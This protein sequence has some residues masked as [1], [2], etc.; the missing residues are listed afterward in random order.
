VSYLKPTPLAELIHLRARIIKIEGRKAWVDCAL[1]AA[2]ELRA[3]G[4]V[5]GVRVNWD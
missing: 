3:T 4:E 1:T 5:L 2:G